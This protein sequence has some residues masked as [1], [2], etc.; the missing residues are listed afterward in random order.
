M[1]QA[2]VVVDAVS[3]GEVYRAARAGFLD[4]VDDDGKGAPVWECV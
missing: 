4:N 1:R 3:A 2:G